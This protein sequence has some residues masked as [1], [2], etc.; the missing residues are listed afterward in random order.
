LSDGMKSLPSDRL[1]DRTAVE[2]KT[3]ERRA[4]P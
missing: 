3:L 4:I 2:L 1:T